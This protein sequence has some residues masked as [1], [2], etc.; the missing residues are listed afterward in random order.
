MND[1]SVAA[2]LGYGVLVP[3]VVSGGLVWL[4][5]RS[6]DE[7]TL[8]R[9]GAALAFVGGFVAGYLLLPDWAALAPERHWHWLPYLA[10]AAGLLGPVSFARGVSLPEARTGLAAHDVGGGVVP[11]TVVVQS[12]TIADILVAVASCR[13]AIDGGMSCAARAACW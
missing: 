6:L 9:Y 5:R 13:D 2:V 12:R 11:R 10:V 8:L 4:A 3:A 7:E 1:D